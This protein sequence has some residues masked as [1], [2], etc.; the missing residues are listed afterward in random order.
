MP[1]FIWIRFHFLIPRPSLSIYYHN[2]L[3][4]STS[5]AGQLSSTVNSP[6]Q[7]T[8]LHSQ[9]FSAV[10]SSPQSLA[11]WYT[12]YKTPKSLVVLLSC[13]ILI[14]ILLKMMKNSLLYFIC[15]LKLNSF[16][17]KSHFV[18]LRVKCPGTIKVP[19]HPETTAVRSRDVP[20]P[21]C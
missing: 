20:G 18:H 2:S 9:L 5:F 21:S 16:C 4:Q 8:L 6:P 14:V 3:P 13:G 17:Y 11:G 1:I 10:N 7:S 15:I 12:T 19:R